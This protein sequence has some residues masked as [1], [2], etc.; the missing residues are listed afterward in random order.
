MVTTFYGVDASR[1]FVDEPR[2]FYDDL[3]RVCSRYFV[4]SDDMRQRVVAQ[5]FP[6]DRVFVHPAGVDL[7]RHPFR[8][9]TLEQEE[10]L[11]LVAV[12]RLVEK[13]GFDDLLRALAVVRDRSSRPFRCVVVGGGPQ[14]DDLLRLRDSLGLQDVVDFAGFMPVDEIIGLFERSHILL[15][16]SKTA[17]DGDME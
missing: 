9:R 15:A 5:G 2:D 7:Q 4:M 11:H 10:T 1:V 8:R 3:K 6:A 13:K 16:P 17:P 14:E 12:G